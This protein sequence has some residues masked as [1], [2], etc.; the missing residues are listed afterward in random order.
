LKF[1][2]KDQRYCYRIFEDRSL[3][4]LILLFLHLYKSR[5]LG[6][7]TNFFTITSVN[8]T[9]D[10]IQSFIFSS[11]SHRDKNNG[12][13]R[14]FVWILRISAPFFPSFKN[15]VSTRKTSIRDRDRLWTFL[16]SGSDKSELWRFYFVTP[17]L[18]R[19]HKSLRLFPDSHGGLISLQSHCLLRYYGFSFSKLCLYQTWQLVFFPTPF[20][21]KRVFVER[22][23]SFLT[24][25]SP[26]QLRVWEICPI[27]LERSSDNPY[28]S[29]R[30]T[31][32]RRLFDVLTASIDVS[33]FPGLFFFLLRGSFCLGSIS[34]LEWKYFYGGAKVFERARVARHFT[35]VTI[36]PINLQLWERPPCSINLPVR[37]PRIFIVVRLSLVLT[38]TLMCPSPFHAEFMNISTSRSSILFSLFDPYILFFFFFSCSSLLTWLLSGRMRDI[39][40][41]EYRVSGSFYL[42]FLPLDSRIQLTSQF[43]RAHPSPV[44]PLRQNF[45]DERVNTPRQH[46]R[47]DQTSCLRFL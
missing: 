32:V 6:K 11:L 25:T 4:C 38:G 23:V 17:L 39:P 9:K 33:V 5:A 22:A 41:V 45:F 47:R 8:L 13:T 15:T 40:V 20:T 35:L 1:L 37:S 36:S 7:F 43:S 2:N 27:N 12:M 19:S 44:H 24:E 26:Q 14:R 34:S 10:N 29:P 16:S 31:L 21:S 28:I 46:K 18:P 30:Q 42:I 3:E